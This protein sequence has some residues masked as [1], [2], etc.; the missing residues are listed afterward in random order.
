MPPAPSSVVRPALLG[1]LVVALL[2]CASQGDGAADSPGSYDW[3]L[4]GGTVVDG[5][6]ADARAADVLIRGD[7]IA[8]V[9]PVDADTIEADERVDL[10]GQTVAPGFIDAH[11]H[12]DPT[13]TPEFRNFLAMGVTTILLGQDGRS[14]RAHALSAHLDSVAAAR[15]FVNVGYL[16]G[17]GTLRAESGIDHGRPSS[18]QRHSLAALVD[19]GLH[20]GAFGLSLGLEYDPGR[21]ARRPEL[22]AVAEPVAARDGVIMS[23]MRS[24]D[25]DEIEA[26]VDE[27]LEQGRATG[28]HVHAA[29]LKIVGSDDPER[30]DAVL[31]QMAAARSEGL[32]VTA[33]VYP[34]TAS[35]TGVSIVF[36]EWARPPNDYETVREQRTEALRSYLTTRIRQRNGPDAMLFGTGPWA[37]R[38]LAEVADEQ[39]RPFAEVLMDVGP[40]GASAAY[41][42]MDEAV[43]ERF[44]AAEHTVVSSDGSPTMHHPRGHGAFARVLSDHTGPDALLSLEEAI[45]KMTGKT[46]SI[47]GLDD[48]GRVATPRGRVQE[49]YAADLVAFDPSAV[50]DRADFENP[51]RRAAGMRRV[52][53]NGRLTWTGDALNPST[54]AG[55][56]L[57]DRR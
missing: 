50:T 22:V 23:H 2:G 48:P 9:G 19:E 51:H 49:G 5:T 40:Q 15:P 47:I 46:A 24:E 37:G 14:P 42:V 16:V 26:S 7:T 11:A 20:A 55:H 1:V 33:D 3:H 43:M 36:P 54:G 56:V 27:L 31:D 17:H 29:H 44:L 39:D 25:A 41:F 13:E 30:A 6:G 4:A 28:A 32:S 21:Q 57:R 53:V 12:G 52:W 18:S 45:H 38:T 35:F 8:H 10:S 34:Y